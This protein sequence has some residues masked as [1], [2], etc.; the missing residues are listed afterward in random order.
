MKIPTVSGSFSCRAAA[1]LSASWR[2]K[3]WRDPASALSRQHSQNGKDSEACPPQQKHHCHLQRRGKGKIQTSVYHQQS[4]A[5]E[6]NQNPALGRHGHTAFSCRDNPWTCSGC[7]KNSRWN[8]KRRPSYFLKTVG[9]ER[10][11]KIYTL[12]R[13]KVHKHSGK[14]MLSCC[15]ITFPLI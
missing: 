3:L 5:R 9:D 2:R 10:V 13:K 8:L 11:K 7:L 14:L 12:L 6:T 15:T 4:P 1:P